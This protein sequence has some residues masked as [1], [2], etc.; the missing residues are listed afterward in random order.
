MP[1]TTRTR[2]TAAAEGSIA[3]FLGAGASKPF[4][5]P[6]TD[7]ILPEVL[8]RMRSGNLFPSAPRRARN[9]EDSA[10]ELNELL[11]QLLPGLLSRKI[12]P[13]LVTDVFSLLDQ[14]VSTD[15]TLAPGVD[16]AAVGRLRLLLERA[17]AEVL[18]E[19]RG[20]RGKAGPALLDKFADWIHDTCGGGR[21]VSVISTNYDFALEQRLLSRLSPRQIAMQVDFGLNW[22]P[23]D[24]PARHRA[25]PRPARPALA[26]LKLH[27]ALNWLRC[28]LCEHLVI[29][30]SEPIF[31]QGQTERG[32]SWRACS[33]GHAPLRHVLVA[34][35]MVRDVRDPNLIGLWQSALEA[36][37]TATEWVIIGYSLPAQDVE[38]RSLLLRAYR[39]RPRPPRVQVVQHG[40]NQETEDRYRVLFP[41][42]V[43]DEGG[44]E[45]FLRRLPRSA[46]PRRSA[47]ATRAARRSRPRRA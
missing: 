15:G 42:L 47:R 28:P 16:P 13:P 24:G 36:L 10:R 3:L 29:H 46:A 25:W 6:V 5:F 2:Q 11:S 37:R 43:F 34:P 1:R 35:S 38:I 23:A 12:V 22:R 26:I 40:R 27:G 30:P 45:A 33:C 18:A 39:G 9:N 7:E 4:G 32:D 8:G 14:I 21:F 41:E 19:P 44:V 31:R 20:R 17:V